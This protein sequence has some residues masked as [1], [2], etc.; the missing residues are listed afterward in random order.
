VCVRKN[1]N[2]FRPKFVGRAEFPPNPPSARPQKRPFR[3]GRFQVFRSAFGGTPSLARF[4]SKFFLTI[5]DNY[6]TTL[7]HLRGAI[8]VFAFAIIL[9]F[10]ATVKRSERM[11][12][13]FAGSTILKNKGLSV[14]LASSTS[15]YQKL[16][17]RL[18]AS[19][20]LFNKILLISKY[21]KYIDEKSTFDGQTNKIS[22]A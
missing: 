19:F 2:R 3:I 5:K 16:S 4:G 14:S 11:L 9:F 8:V 20:D 22:Y 17:A 15:T 10:S 18:F 21:S 1:S 6:Q 7:S 12:L 13:E